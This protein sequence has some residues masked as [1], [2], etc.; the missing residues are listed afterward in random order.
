ML[1]PDWSKCM[2]RLPVIA[3]RI[4]FLAMA[5][6]LAAALTACGDQSM[7][8]RGSDI[9]GAAVGGEF[10]MPDHTGKV[11]KLSDLRARSW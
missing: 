8:F 6:M 4:L 3:Q 5:A 9:T 10:S 7:K 2:S 11:R 1:E